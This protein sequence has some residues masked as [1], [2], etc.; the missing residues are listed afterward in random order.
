MSIV[1]DRALPSVVVAVIVAVP[2][3]TAVTTPELLTVATE[4]LLL[5][6]FKVLLLTF[7]GVKVGLIC[8]LL[9]PTLIE[10]GVVDNERAVAIRFTVTV[11]IEVFPPSVVV[12]VIVVIPGPTPVTSPVEST[13]AIVLSAED[14]L[15]ELSVA[16]DG[17]I[18]TLSNLVSP[19]RIVAVEFVI[20]TPVTGKVIVN[21]YVAWNFPSLVVAVIIT[22]AVPVV[23]FMVTTPEELT[24][25][26]VV[27]LLVQVTVLTVALS[28]ATWAVR[29][30]ESPFLT[31]ALP[32]VKVTAPGVVE[33]V[34]PV[35][36]TGIVTLQTALKPPSFVTADMLTVPG[37]TACTTPVVAST[38][39]TAVSSLDQRIDLSVEVAGNTVGK[40]VSV[41][42]LI[43]KV[44]V[45]L[46][47][48][49][50]LTG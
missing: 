43:V 16:F 1:A 20:L 49:M 21:E 22:G 10:V 31:E 35:T 46:S 47:S 36:E 27:L 13:V 39:A 15:H 3:P 33:S 30:I 48:L 8:K 25:A 9:V 38:V 12:A 41:E 50:L 29:D 18:A 4:V 34:I 37:A 45:F 40:R 19:T 24:V 14:Q 2:A 42:V 17:K 23:F 6:H 32:F 5:D 11:Q 44:A 7:A 28:G 26:Y